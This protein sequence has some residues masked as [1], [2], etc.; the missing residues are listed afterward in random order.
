MKIHL[1]CLG[2][3]LALS[4]VGKVNAETGHPIRTSLCEVDATPNRFIGKL[5]EVYGSIERGIH[6]DVISDNDC[7]YGGAALEVTDAVLAAAHVDIHALNRTMF[8]P[9]PQGKELAFVGTVVGRVVANGRLARPRLV[10]TSMKVSLRPPPPPRCANGA[11]PTVADKQAAT[12]VAAAVISKQHFGSRVKQHGLETD[13]YDSGWMWWVTLEEPEATGVSSDEGR[14]V[15]D[16][17]IEKCTGAV[18]HMVR[19]E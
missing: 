9:D 4:V 5:V 15:L 11:P 16:F 10:A 8:L 12:R 7:R 17:D 6:G 13:V 2:L 14:V 18:T 19:S 1:A 3:A